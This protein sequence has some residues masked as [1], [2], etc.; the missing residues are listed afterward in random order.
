MIVNKENTSMQILI[1]FSITMHDYN[2]QYF[3]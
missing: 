3:L 2:T 1:L